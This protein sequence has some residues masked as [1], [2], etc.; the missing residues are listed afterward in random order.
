MT[1]S[2]DGGLAVSFNLKNTGPAAS[3]EVPQVYLGEPQQKQAGNFPV[4]A[5]VGF[6]RIHLAAGE[7]KDV[8]INVPQRR[9]Q[10]WNT[11]AA[12]WAVAVG[13]RP[14]LVGGSSRDLPLT[15]TVTIQ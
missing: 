2:A 7:A 8:T 3:D 1:E 4:H 12:Q 11:D 14:V 10:Y 6:E 9:L 5:L 13:P 15:A